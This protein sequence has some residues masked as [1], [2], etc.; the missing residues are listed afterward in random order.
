MSDP[1]NPDKEALILYQKSVKIAIKPEYFSNLF[2]SFSMLIIK[3]FI[4]LYTS[5]QI[6][7]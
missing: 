1:E 6:Y 2:L 4:H 5:T 3:M 7:A